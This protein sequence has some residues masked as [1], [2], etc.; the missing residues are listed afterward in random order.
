MNKDSTAYEMKTEY[1]FSK[2][3]RGK[4]HKKNARFRLPIYLDNKLE[5]ELIALSEKKGM[6]LSDFVHRL[7]KKDVSMLKEML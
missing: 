2:G 1:D 6:V 7:L 4:F 5:Q 3:E